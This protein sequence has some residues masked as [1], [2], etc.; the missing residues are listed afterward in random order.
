MKNNW[1]GVILEESL[2][3]KSLIKL[4]KII[5]TEKDNLEGEDRVMTFHKVEVEDNKKD[6]FIQKAM[7][8]I[9]NGF[10]THLVK[11]KVM[12]VIF[13]NHMFKF[14]KG[15]PELEE[16]RKYG[17]ERG[18]KEEQMPFEHLLENPWD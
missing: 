10:Y 8:S 15:Y 5:S 18:I 4:T 14:S 13:N 3:D 16:A 2:E 9:K 1:K 6:E 12:Y 7:K 17:K 11:D